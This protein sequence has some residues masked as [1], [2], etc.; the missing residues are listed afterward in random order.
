MLGFSIYVAINVAMMASAEAFGSALFAN[1]LWFMAPLAF[2]LCL[3]VWTVSLWELSPV[4]S[5]RVSSTEPGID[6]QDVAL[7]LA[8]FNRE[9]SKLTHK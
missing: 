9:L 7:E 6:T 1:L 2:A 5:V 4:P 3:I 8:R